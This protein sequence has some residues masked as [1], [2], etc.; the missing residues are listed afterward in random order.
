MGSCNPQKKIPRAQ[1]WLVN[2]P[3]CGESPMFIVASLLYTLSKILHLPDNLDV[4]I[5]YNIKQY[6]TM[7]WPSYPYISTFIYL[8]QI[9]V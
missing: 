2:F 7:M 5:I 3:T 4:A 6:K 9:Y 1:I 8:N